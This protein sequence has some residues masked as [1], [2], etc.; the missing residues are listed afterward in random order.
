MEEISNELRKFLRKFDLTNY[1][2]NTYLTLMN[3]PTL[4]AKE[5]SAKSRVPS[6][7]I[8]DILDR[9][10]SFGLIEV[11]DTRPKKYK[12]IK[13]NSAFRS[14]IAR[15][16]EKN[17]KESQ[18]LYSQARELEKDIQ[19]SNILGNAQAPSLFW[20]TSYGMKAIS[21][22]YRDRIRDLE[23]EI[24]L[25]G[26]INENTTKVMPQAKYLFGG[27]V[28][29]IERH[30]RARF[31]WSFDL[32]ERNPSP[33]QLEKNDR[34]YRQLIDTLEL[35][36]RLSSIGGDFEMKYVNQRISTYFDI[37]DDKRVIL[38]L[39]NPV[40]PTQI[41]ACISVLDPNLAQELKKY[42]TELWN[43]TAIS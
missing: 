8:Y 41:F 7:R 30:G 14:L 32:D 10:T 33:T 34:I 13:P 4:S 37:F 11:Q 9:L 38:K 1:D 36:L 21:A 3:A 40:K 12:I 39:R 17:Q 26:F 23:K 5:I 25:T 15:F 22:V 20:S 35:A 19:T 28:N 24:L 31:L 16:D 2:I 6:G 42:Y 18:L 27:L 29:F 43:T